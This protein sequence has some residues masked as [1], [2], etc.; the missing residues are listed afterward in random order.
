LLLPALARLSSGPA[1]RWCSWIAPPFEPFA[2][3][4]SVHGV[5]LERVLVVR[6]ATPLWACEQALRSGACDVALAWIRRGDPRQF[7][8]LQLAAEQGRTLGFVFRT[9][10]ARASS[11]PSCAAL[12]ISVGALAEGARITL[13][14][15][16]GGLRGSIDLA[17]HAESGS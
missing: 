14:K 17:L 2:P 15:S 10:S 7:R 8:R 13:L 3:A 9:L 1:A 16:R 6:A 4:L 12:R 11:E 5:T